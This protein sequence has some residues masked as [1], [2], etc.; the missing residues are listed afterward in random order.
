MADAINTRVNAAQAELQKRAE[1]LKRIVARSKG[2]MANAGFAEGVKLVT[3]M[4]EG[5][6]K[7]IDT[8]VFD[9]PE[10]KL[11][12]QRNLILATGTPGQSVQDGIKTTTDAIDAMLE[13][14][15]QMSR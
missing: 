2:K 13:T 7:L 4:I 5:Q 8:L 15:E 9:A 1:K 12:Q 3:Q 11:E 6:S 10:T 14:L